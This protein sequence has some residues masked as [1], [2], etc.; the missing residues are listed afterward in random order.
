MNKLNMNIEEHKNNV[1]IH[2]NNVTT[3][4]TV[5]NTIK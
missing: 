5:A 2:K 3:V 4:F 1:K